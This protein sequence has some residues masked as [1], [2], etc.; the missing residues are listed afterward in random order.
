MKY[1]RHL[2]VAISLASLTGAV[3]ADTTGDLWLIPVGMACLGQNEAYATAW[4]SRNVLGGSVI[5]AAT[6][7]AFRQCLRKHAPLSAKL[8]DDVMN[9]R[10]ETMNDFRSIYEQHSEEIVAMLASWRSPSADC[11]AAIK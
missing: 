3:T 1:A 11:F 2:I 9:L 4:F 10:E 5:E 6:S 8:C 7:S